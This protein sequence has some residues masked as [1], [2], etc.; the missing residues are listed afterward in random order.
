MEKNV[1]DED[2]QDMTVRFFDAQEL[3]DFVTSGTSA[4]PKHGVLQKFITP[5]GR[6][7][8]VIQVSWSVHVTLIEK[9][10]NLKELADLKCSPYEKLVTYEGPAQYSRQAHLSPNTLVEVKRICKAIVDHVQQTEHHTVTRM[11]LYLK[12]DGSNQ[13]WLMWSNMMR[14]REH[15]RDG[16]VREKQRRRKPS[17]Q[18]QSD[19]NLQKQLADVGAQSPTMGPIA[20]SYYVYINPSNEAKRSNFV[21]P[22]FQA[23]TIVRHREPRLWAADPEE[24]SLALALH[25]ES[26]KQKVNPDKK[27]NLFGNKTPVKGPKKK[28]RHDVD[29]QK[30]R[31][32]APTSGLDESDSDPEWSFNPSVLSSTVPIA[33]GQ[34]TGYGYAASYGT[35]DGFQ[36]AYQ[37]YGDDLGP[38]P[39]SI[40]LDHSYLLPLNAAQDANKAGSNS[41]ADQNALSIE[42]SISMMAQQRRKMD[43]EQVSPEQR[44]QLHDLRHQLLQEHCRSLKQ[45]RQQIHEKIEFIDNL[46][47]DAQASGDSPKQALVQLHQQEAAAN[48]KPA[49]SFSGSLAIGSDAN[50][51]HIDTKSDAGT[52]VSFGPVVHNRSLSDPGLG[53]EKST[54]ARPILDPALV[55]TLRNPTLEWFE[56]L[57]YHMYCHFLHGNAK[58]P[59]Y[60]K[61][62]L[63]LVPLWEHLNK[64]LLSLEGWEHCSGKVFAANEGLDATEQN[65]D[66]SFPEDAEIYFVC[67]KKPNLVIIGER[68]EEFAEEFLPEAPE[69]A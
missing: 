60:F 41:L 63:Q 25:A 59:Y 4:C 28:Q 58:A 44:K 6:H 26:V 67:S 45:Q 48:E 31:T 3:S 10:L 33:K 20:D 8:E 30:A 61:L 50:E 32:Y 43:M 5:P 47:S 49:Y 11:T 14:I 29:P 15:P 55:Q 68:F 34:Q 39:T 24:S 22:K 69:V 56:E 12:L 16:H 53:Q 23:R 65:S 36:A 57:L 40:L 13:L 38:P 17:L 42:E 7:N 52:V 46:L 1:S 19:L 37:G 9:R 62:P 18:T 21:L 2:G 35:L 64:M 54:E 27:V 66:D 51:D